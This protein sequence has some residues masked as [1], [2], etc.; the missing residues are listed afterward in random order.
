MITHE[1][2]KIKRF[3][4]DG[5]IERERILNS[6]PP[7]FS[8]KDFD[9]A[10]ATLELNDAQ[11]P[12]PAKNPPDPHI[13]AKNNHI[14]TE[15]VLGIINDYMKYYAGVEQYVEDRSID[16]DLFPERLRDCF[17]RVYFDVVGDDGARFGEELFLEIIRRLTKGKLNHCGPIV[18][19]LVHYFAR[20]EVFPLHPGEEEHSI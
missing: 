2:E 6:A 5:M 10:C 9:D 13:K 16:D 20:C 17:R 4:M 7:E 12:T 8:A 1:L 3:L 14:D 15:V 19:L 11:Q 18:A